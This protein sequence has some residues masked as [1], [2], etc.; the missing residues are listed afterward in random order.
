MLK[1]TVV[2]TAVPNGRDAATFKLACLA[3]PRL[4][5]DGNPPALTLDLF[6][7]FKNWAATAGGVTF[8][9][10]FGNNP[11]VP[12]KRVSPAPRPDLW[13]A[14]FPPATYVRPF[15]FSDHTGEKIRSYPVVHVAD[16]IAKLYRDVAVSS[17][18]QF[19]H[20]SALLG[21]LLPSRIAMPQG[22][23]DERYFLDLLESKFGG[24][25]AIPPGPAEPLMDFL[26]AK[27]FHLVRKDSK[28]APPKPTPEPLDFHRVLALLMEYPV[29]QRLLGLVFDLT[30]PLPPGLPANTT[31]QVL[32]T[33]PT[34][35]PGTVNVSPVTAA[36]YSA[37]T[38]LPKDSGDVVAGAVNLSS[39][40]FAVTGFD[41][42]GSALKVRQFADN[43]KRA[44]TVARSGD[45]PD[46]YGL[47]ALRS[48]GLAVVRTGRAFQQ[49]AKLGAAKANN[50]VIAG[51]GAPALDAGSLLHG[52]RWHVWDAKSGRWYSLCQRTGEYEFVTT[53][54]KI[55]VNGWEEG[56]TT[57]AM[58]K[59]VDGAQVIPD[60]YLAEYLCRWHGESL[61]A[62]RPGNSLHAEPDQ[63]PTDAVPGPPAEFALRALFRPQPGTLPPLRFGRRY[64]LRAVATF[65]GGAGL[66]FQPGDAVPNFAQATA[67]VTY[68]RVEPIPHPEVVL[69]KP[70][71]A[72][73]AV[74]HLVIRTDFDLTDPSATTP[75]ER[76]IVPPKTAQLTAEQHGM[77]DRVGGIPT[78]LYAMLAARADGTIG[79]SDADPVFD[80]DQL[81]FPVEAG[82][83]A[84]IPWLPDP[85]ARRAAFFGLPGVP[86]AESFPAEFGSEQ[87]GWPNLQPF[88]L[89]L[90]EGAG[91][92]QWTSLRELTVRIGKGDVADVELSS[93]PDAADLQAMQVWRWVEYGAGLPPATLDARR[94]EARN[95][96]NWLLTPKR[97][98]TLVCAVRR[99]LVMPAFQQPVAD[100]AVLGD[101]FATVQDTLVI[102]RK[103]TASV[104]LQAQWTD[105]VDD[106]VGEV[107]T[108][109]K[110]V[111]RTAD[112]GEVKA[113]PAGPQLPEGSLA[114]QRRHELGDTRAHTV[115]YTAVAK[116]RFAEYFAEAKQ[117]VL[118]P[119]GTVGIDAR[120]VAPL[121]EV[122]R[123]PGGATTYGR[124]VDYAIDY[125]TGLLTRLPSGGI[126]AGATL[127]VK[128][129]P[130]VSRASDPANPVATVTV[131]SS[132]RP[133]VP[134]PR[135]I[136]PTFGWQ[137]H[138]PSPDPNL[139]GDALSRRMGNG[140]RVYL[141]RPWWSSGAGE[142]LA[143][144]LSPTQAPTAQLRQYVTRWG[145]D[146]V[147][148][149][150]PPV[151]D[152][153]M[154]S[155]FPRRTS[156]PALVGLADASGLM[157][158][159]APHE[160]V[161]DLTPGNGPYAPGGKP[162]LWYCDIELAPG[163]VYFPFV[164]LALARYQPD[165]LP[166]AELSPVVVTD[167]AQLT[168]DRWV[169]LNHVS[170]LTVAVTVV[171][172]DYEKTAANQT[173]H[174]RIVVTVEQREPGIPG[175]LGWTAVGEYALSPGIG[176]QQGKTIWSGPV[177]LPAPRGSQPMRLV[178][179][180]Y[181][182]LSASQAGDRVVFADVIDVV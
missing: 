127:D 155:Q 130:T 170:P 147:F 46:R 122:V 181:E 57:T 38:F 150:A 100:R 86:A 48:A 33:W 142:Q 175:A 115:T 94:T 20:A 65:V 162:R 51:G 138:R 25:K 43:V 23:N 68:A 120:G 85:F 164:R 178:V 174:G 28:P 62:R 156:S 148:T 141:D 12:A 179:R 82:G 139:P 3:A 166:G 34:S 59:R 163:A 113:A 171:G 44:W 169:T 134:V 4:S 10:K 56:P 71:T 26:Q 144:V 124:G 63:P 117:V 172:H 157:V 61:V 177:T 8:G 98:L 5:S 107:W 19:P 81:S 55:P 132:A 101:T 114:V 168:P 70:T 158:S 106:L 96:R 49:V 37:A 104:D 95:G 153:P 146:P 22:R 72:G 39:A 161:P 123:A 116:S 97:K 52:V 112:L 42:D 16:A 69:R 6:A 79:G 99:P 67:E 73:E 88:R 54:T 118:T 47:P 41:V 111:A 30:V 109:A 35:L 7:D 45:T 50:G 128:Y 15:V 53:Q 160:V 1:Q 75:T 9:V 40:G 125:P 90:V 87:A 31:V 140:L 167:F 11:P 110:Q 66:P 89:R 173:K 135:Q 91:A 108:P 131:R 74:H 145:A 126:G 83:T 27:R 93:A 136:V 64:R 78:G 36:T 182:R 84:Q 102:S 77:F 2:W 121:S 103:S 60:F 76:H 133:A 129:L 13:S 92:P 105:T 152:L 151:T 143:V 165:A 32:A 18:T 29:I 154:Q 180:E 159:V 176:W 24:N 17:P 58:T 119:D 137:L 14:L 149:S 21:D 80:T